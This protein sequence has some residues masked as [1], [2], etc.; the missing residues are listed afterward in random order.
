MKLLKYIP[1]AL[2]LTGCSAGINMRYPRGFE[3]NSAHAGSGYTDS[4]NAALAQGEGK[5]YEEQKDYVEDGDYISQV[6]QLD[7]GTII[8][9]D[10]EIYIVET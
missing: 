1:I 10:D 6:I 4:V 9:I 7:D 8:I 2:L 3:G 5:A